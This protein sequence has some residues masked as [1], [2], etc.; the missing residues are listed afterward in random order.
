MQEEPEH[1]ALL[2]ST[3]NTMHIKSSSC[4]VMTSKVHMDDQ[5][6]HIHEKKVILVDSDEGNDVWVLD[7]G[8]SNHMTGG[9]RHSHH[10]AN[11]YATQW[12]LAMDHSSRYRA[13]AL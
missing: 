8:A 10:S 2:M 11:L 7:M 5:V 13:L 1:P 4:D 9:L 3:V 6:V 12:V